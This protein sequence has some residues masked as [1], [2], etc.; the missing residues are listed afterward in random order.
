MTEMAAPGISLSE[1]VTALPDPVRQ[2]PVLADQKRQKH[3]V[4]HPG[5]VL[6]RGTVSIE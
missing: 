2:A 6:F 5:D 1:P 3:L 4:N